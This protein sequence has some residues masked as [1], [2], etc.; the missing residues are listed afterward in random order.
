MKIYI[1]LCIYGCLF[2]INYTRLETC[3]YLLCKYTLSFFFVDVS[4]FY[5]YFLVLLVLTMDWRIRTIIEFSHI[6]EAV[7][8]RI[9]THLKKLTSRKRGA[10]LRD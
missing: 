7:F 2:F 5:F 3:T 6:H 1:I 4:G 10:Y 9:F 8:T